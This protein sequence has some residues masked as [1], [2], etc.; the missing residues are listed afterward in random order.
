MQGSDFA[1]LYL[2]AGKPAWRDEFFY[3]HPT[4]RNTGFIPSS[5]ALVSKEIKYIYWPD[6]G[7]EEVFDLKRDPFEEHNLAHN[8]VF[9]KPLA[10]LRA[11]FAE[12]KAQAR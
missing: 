7:Y 8:A 12:L 1:P 5:E 9:V 4:I 6:F 2:A 3:E 10:V 11:R